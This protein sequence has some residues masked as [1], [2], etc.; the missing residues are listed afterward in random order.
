MAS[1]Q[2]GKFASRHRFLSRIISSRPASCLSSRLSSRS[3]IPLVRLALS[4]CRLIACSYR[5]HL[6]SCG[7]LVGHLVPHLV[8]SPCCLAHRLIVPSCRGVLLARLVFFSFVL[9]PS[10]CG[11]RYGVPAWASCYRIIPMGVRLAPRGLRLAPYLLSTKPL[12]GVRA[13]PASSG[14]EAARTA[15]H[16]DNDEMSWTKRRGRKTGD[17]RA[18]HRARQKRDENETMRRG[19]I[20]T[21]RAARRKTGR[22]TRRMSEANEAMGQRAEGS[23]ERGKR[24]R[25]DR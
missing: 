1:W 6:V 22:R 12:C 15:K 19:N 23:T 3:C 11:F 24:G 2:V 4:S 21:R 16:G 17:K 20:R 13:R 14:H 5:S 7:R 25:L 18:A 8:L 9:S 10:P